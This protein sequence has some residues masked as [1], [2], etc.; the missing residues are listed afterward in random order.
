MC[1]PIKFF[2]FLC[3]YFHI[4]HMYVM[5]RP[6]LGLGQFDGKCTNEDQIQE[7]EF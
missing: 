1:I 4:N 2:L 3:V 5:S 7:R 6:E